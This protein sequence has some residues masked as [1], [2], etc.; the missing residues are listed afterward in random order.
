[1]SSGHRVAMPFVAAEE[2][3]PGEHHDSGRFDREP[4]G[5]DGLAP[6]KGIL[7]GLA[8][9]ILFWVVVFAAWCL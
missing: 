7:V 1:M 8:S 5:V 4:G 9:S 2:T 6:A 3:L